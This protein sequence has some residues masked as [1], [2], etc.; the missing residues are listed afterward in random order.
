MLML[1]STMPNS[2]HNSHVIALHP[3]LHS[4]RACCMMTPN[5]MHPVALPSLHGKKV[6]GPSIPLHP[7]VPCTQLCAHPKLSILHRF[8]LALSLQ[9]S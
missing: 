9:L 7:A 2:G 6:A 5:S 4:S 3:K 1:Y 8:L